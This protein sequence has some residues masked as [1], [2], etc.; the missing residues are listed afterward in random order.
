MHTFLIQFSFSLSIFSHTLNSFLFLLLFLYSVRQIII[1][2]YIIQ[3]I[4][5]LQF[6]KKKYYLFISECIP[7]LFNSP[8]LSFFFF[9][10]SS[11]LSILFY[12]LRQIIL[13]IPFSFSFS[14]CP[15]SSSSSFSLSMLF[16]THMHEHERI[17]Y[18]LH[19]INLKLT[20]N[21]SV[22]C[23]NMQWQSLTKQA[24]LEN[25][26]ASRKRCNNTFETFEIS[27]HSS[28]DLSCLF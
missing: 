25:Q 1:L 4:S 27:I 23:Q 10:F 16:H 26:S 19:T 24:Q 15:S 22:H 2:Y 6:S 17:Y 11:S 14:I 7:F 12:T 18:N 9:S 3:I 8:F 21:P 28:I 13:S 5:S 20:I